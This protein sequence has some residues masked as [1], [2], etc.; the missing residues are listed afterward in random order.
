MVSWRAL[1]QARVV[2]LKNLLVKSRTR[3]Q[4]AAELFYPVYFIGILALLQLSSPPVYLPDAPAF[5]PRPLEG[6]LQGMHLLYAPN[7]SSHANAA[8]QQLARWYDGIDTRAFASEA[9]MVAFHAAAQ[10]PSGALESMFAASAGSCAAAGGDGGAALGGGAGEQ[11][12]A[13]GVVFGELLP[14]A[15]SYTLRLHAHHSVPLFER[16][17]PEQ[18]SQNGCLLLFVESPW[19]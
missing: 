10:P 3:S 2:T 12:P 19:S 9:E 11:Q 7:A 4:T 17:P 8:M 6:S 1:R 16:L 5:P 18:V 13:V 14:T 15:A